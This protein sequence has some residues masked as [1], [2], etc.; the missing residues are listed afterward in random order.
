MREDIYKLVCIFFYSAPHS[1]EAWVRLH[2]S[3]CG[4]QALP[5]GFLWVTSETAYRSECECV[6]VCLCG[7]IFQSKLG[8]TPAPCNLQWDKAIED[9]WMDGLP[10]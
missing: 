3:L 1:N 5:G 7:H 8:L 10:V 6:F 2:T 4:V 9:E